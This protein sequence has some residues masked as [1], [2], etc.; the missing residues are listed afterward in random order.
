MSLLLEKNLPVRAAS[1][2]AISG[3]ILPEALSG[4]VSSSLVCPLW[5][6]LVFLCRALLGD[7]GRA[8]GLFLR[9]LGCLRFRFWFRFREQ[10]TFS[11]RVFNGLGRG[12]GGIRWRVGGSAGELATVVGAVGAIGAFA[13][14]VVGAASGSLPLFLLVSAASASASALV[15][16]ALVLALSSVIISEQ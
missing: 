12:L 13:D 10:S 11:V 5:D 16:S 9:L 15:A 14:S 1:W 6:P 7:C 3:T 8:L 2:G 4:L